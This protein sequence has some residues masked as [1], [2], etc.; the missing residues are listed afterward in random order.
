MPAT[1]PSSDGGDDRLPVSENLHLLVI[2]SIRGAPV[3]RAVFRTCRASLDAS[4]SP[5]APASSARTSPTRSSRTAPRCSCSTT[6]PPAGRRTS[7]PT[8]SFER[9][10]SSTRSSSEGDRRLRAG[11]R[12]PPRGAGERHR[13]GRAPGARPRGERPRHAERLRSGARRWALRSSSPRP[14]ARSTGTTPHSRRRSPSDPRPLSPYGA[15]KLAGEAYVATWGAPARAPE[16]RAAARQR[17]RAAAAAAR[18]GRRRRDLLRPPAPR[19]AADVSR[20]RRADAR[21]RPRRRRRATRSSPPLR[22][23]VRGRSTSARLERPA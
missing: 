14:A 8:P 15:S 4:S 6:S 17:V 21:L 20:L 12:L 18:R 13:V 5:E 10:T 16:R 19:R 23:V 3:L 9:S 1:S 11:R 2:S 7:L 22:R